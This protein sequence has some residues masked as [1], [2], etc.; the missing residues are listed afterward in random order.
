MKRDPRI[1]PIPG[2]VLEKKYQGRLF[3]ARGYMEREV[4]EVY[5]DCVTQ[6]C[7]RNRRVVYVGPDVCSPDISINAWRK[8]AKGAKVT[9]QAP[10]EPEAPGA[11]A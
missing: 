9:K 1:D 8:W 11:S 4:D 7:P 6:S 3:E 5:D 10:A 2:D